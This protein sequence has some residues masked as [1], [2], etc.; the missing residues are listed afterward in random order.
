MA[1]NS[2]AIPV[3]LA[4]SILAYS[5]LRGKNVSA[6]LNSL[7]AGKNPAAIPNSGAV[8]PVSGWG[9]TV[10]GAG[11]DIA[12]AGL[13]YV[14][15]P[16]RWAGFTPNGWDCSGFCNYVIGH[17]LQ[18]AIP[19]VAAGKFNASWHGPPAAL[20]YVWTGATD[21]PRG[22]AQSGDLACWPTHMGICVDN[23]HMVN[24]YTWGHPTAVTGIEEMNP[25]GEI[26]KVRRI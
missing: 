11:G 23:A 12:S 20:W 18:R 4:G 10:A 5:G 9:S 8:M 6:V 7:V 14:G 22:E 24:A 16:Y 19:G 1:L 13:K 2:K 3:L 15:V 21:V 17:D 25:P 26:L